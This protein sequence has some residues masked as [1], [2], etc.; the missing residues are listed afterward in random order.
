MPAPT[1]RMNP[2]RYRSTCDGVS[3]SFGASRDVGISVRDHLWAAPNLRFET[4]GCF[5]GC[6]AGI[7][8]KFRRTSSDFPVAWAPATPGHG[9]A[10]SPVVPSPP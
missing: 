10:I 6:S 5:C 8:R 7:G 1:W 9:Q 3:A 4:V 2:A